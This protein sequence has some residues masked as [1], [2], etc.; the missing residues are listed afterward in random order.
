MTTDNVVF[1][2]FKSPHV[3]DD[4]TLAL[5]SCVFCHNKTFNFIHDKTDDFPMMRRAACGAHMGR[6][7]WA[8]DDDPLLHGDS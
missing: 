2:K 3:E 8:H 5:M 6:M 4:D 7:G 1:L